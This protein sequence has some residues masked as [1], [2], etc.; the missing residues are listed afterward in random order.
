MKYITLIAFITLVMSSAKAEKIINGLE[1]QAYKPVVKLSMGENSRCTGTFIKKGYILTAAHCVSRYYNDVLLQA[2]RK[3][4]LPLSTEKKLNIDLYIND[5]GFSRVQNIFMV[6]RNESGF[7]IRGSYLDFHQQLS[8]ISNRMPY[9][10]R[11]I[12]F[13]SNGEE[14]QS[15]TAAFYRTPDDLSD[16]ERDFA[17]IKVRPR[18]YDKV[19]PVSFQKLQENQDVTIV[20]YG[21]SITKQALGKIQKQA[22]SLQGKAHTTRSSYIKRTS[23]EK[24][25]AK[26]KIIDKNQSGKKHYGFNEIHSV[27]NGLYYLQGRAKTKQESI[28]RFLGLFYSWDQ[29]DATQA[30]VSNGDSGGPLLVKN[31][32]SYLVHGVAAQIFNFDCSECIQELKSFG[33]SVPEEYLGTA[34]S[35]FVN[36]SSTVF[37][38]FYNAVIKD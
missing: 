23:Q 25:E 11:G 31:N 14:L 19:Y 35:V 16:I 4:I 37:Y 17:I 20:G 26:Q 15:I 18:L 13:A 5:E 6:P 29:A 27:T 12:P 38:R 8:H 3:P 21:L 33:V 9:Q 22:F 30:T 10:S 36:S 1:T 2:V 32:N 34:F 24:L 7:D 28:N